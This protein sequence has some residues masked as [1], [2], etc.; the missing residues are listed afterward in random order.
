DP[1]AVLLRQVDREKTR[2]INEL[3]AAGVP[4]EDRIAALETVSWP[5]PLGDTIYAFYDAYKGTHPWVADHNI[6]PKGV[7]RE[8]AEAYLS[9]ADYVKD[10]GLQRSEGVLLRYISEGY[11][12]L[13]QN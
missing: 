13:V 7:L 10:L 1:R 2:I 6:R 9:F 3:K 11:K 5:R 12:A 8:M 4:Y